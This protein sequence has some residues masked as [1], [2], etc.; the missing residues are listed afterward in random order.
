[1]HAPQEFDTLKDDILAYEFKYPVK[2]GDRHLPIIPSRK[3]ERY[4]S[5][6][7][8][9]ADARQR[10]VSELVSFQDRVTISVTVSPSDL[11]DALTVLV[12]ALR[13]AGLFM[14]VAHCRLALLRGSWRQSPS[15][16]GPPG[17]LQT[18]SCKTGKHIRGCTH[19]RI[20]L[21][22]PFA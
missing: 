11:P 15:R 12:L 14:Q 6:A 21:V 4:S 3:P 5:A 16:I 17:R 8:L 1:M 2:I 9:S 13:E 19:K 20:A 10:I 22:H 18:Q 7:P